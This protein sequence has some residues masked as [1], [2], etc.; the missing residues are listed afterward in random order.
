M[1]KTLLGGALCALAVASAAAAPTKLEASSVETKGAFVEAL[2][3]AASVKPDATGRSPYADVPTGSPLWGYVHKALE[4]GVVKPDAKRTFG[5][6]DALTAAQAAEMTVAVYHMDLGAT[7]PFQWAKSQG[8]L[9]Q[10]GVLTTADAAHLIAGLK[11]LLRTLAEIPGS[12]SLPADKRA[13]LLRAMTNSAKAPYIQLQEN[14]AEMYKTKWSSSAQKASAE[15]EL[16][17]LLQSMSMQ[18]TL[19]AQQMHVGSHTYAVVQ[20][21]VSSMAGRHTVQVVNDD[22]AFYEQ[23]DGSGWKIIQSKFADSQVMSLASGILTHVTWAGRQGSFDVFRSQINP[24]AM[25]Q[26][27]SELGLGKGDPSKALLHAT[28]DIT[29][30]IDNSSGAP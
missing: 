22:G 8:L 17:Q 27:I 26:L 24:A 18:L 3:Q 13:E 21:N 10:Q 28:G 11:S 23:Q 4:L 1:R 16:N 14:M 9:S 2:L 7:S 19:S 29:L 25:L 5:A 15:A 30:T 20:E 12:W 6:R